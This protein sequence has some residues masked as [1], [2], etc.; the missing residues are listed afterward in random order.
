MKEPPIRLEMYVEEGGRVPFEEWVN[1]LKDRKALA[2]VD[3]RLIR[4]RHGNYGHIRSV[5]TGV[6]E[7][8]VD[9]GPGYRVYYAASEKTVILLLCGGDKR[10]Q[11][12]D[13]RRAKKYWANFQKRKEQKGV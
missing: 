4:L 13:I 8:K 6:F 2:A 3:M 11:Q 9:I 1:S 7:L 12:S 5:G 10:K